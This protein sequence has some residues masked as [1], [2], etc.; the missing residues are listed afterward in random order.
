MEILENS[1]LRVETTENDAALH[2]IIVKA[3]NR[4]TTLKLE[5][6]AAHLSHSSFSGNVLFPFAGRIKGAKIKNLILDANEGNN[7]LHGGKE[8]QKAVFTRK[9]KAKTSITYSL[10]RT[11]GEDCLPVDRDYFI[12]YTLQDNALVVNLKMES[13]SPTLVD[14][15]LH[16]YFNL[17]GEKTI[18]NHLIKVDCDA[19]VIN[20]SE[21]CAKEL[22]PVKGTVFD[23]NTPALLKN[24]VTSDHPA[25]SKGLNNA[26]R[27]TGKVELK[28]DD[29]TLIASSDSEAVVLYSGDYLDVPSSHIAI[30]FESLPF[31]ENRE[32]SDHFSR[33]IK[34]EFD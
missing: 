31:N 18:E 8:A 7:S 4:E 10:H 6:E 16:S 17:S 22:I 28:C 1:F 30:E 12:T 14:M 13:D 5:N 25:L 23:L 26:F 29:L 33:T 11:K 19:V 3:L 27:L 21:H 34:F 20:D 24:I 9:D 32:F 2:S 15:S